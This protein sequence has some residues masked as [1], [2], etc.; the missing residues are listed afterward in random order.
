MGSLY[1]Y[2]KLNLIING[3]AILILS[4]IIVYTSLY[5]KRGKPEDKAYF[6][7]VITNIIT[8]A[9]NGLPYIMT[10]VDFQFGDMPY[11]V[12]Y[13]AYFVCYNLFCMFWSLYLVYRMKWTGTKLK[14]GIIVFGLPAFIMAVISLV[15]LN[16]FGIIDA[17]VHL[18]GGYDVEFYYVQRYLPVIIYVIC[19]IMI[20]VKIGLRVLLLF[21]P[22][23]AAQCYLETVMATDITPLFLTVYLIYAHL[24]AMRDAFYEEEPNY[25][26]N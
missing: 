14:I 23:F 24:F 5:R 4:G 2:G 26:N 25:D 18:P 8:A 20:T 7:L 6:A 9:V 3:A 15:N 21:V 13:T 11:K 10:A 17:I 22:L 16:S 19:T 12:V 1:Y